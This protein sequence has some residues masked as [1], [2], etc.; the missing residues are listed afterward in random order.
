MEVAILARVVPSIVL[1][2]A[3]HYRGMEEGPDFQ[4]ALNVGNPDWEEFSRDKD[5]EPTSEEKQRDDW[6]MLMRTLGILDCDEFEKQLVEFLESGLFEPARIKAVI[7]RYVE[8]EE[9]ML[10]RDAAQRFLKQFYWDHRVD[11]TQLVAEAADL[12]RSAGLLDPYV[13]TRL[14]SV[15]AQLSGG[16]EVG[17]AFID[18]WILAFRNSRQ[19]IEI[20]DDPFNNPFNNPLHPKIQAEF[21]AIKLTA[22]ANATI[23]EACIHIIENGGWGTLQEVALKQAT[24]ADFEAAIRETEDLDKFLRFMRQMIKMRREKNTYNA[25]FGTATERFVGACRA[26]VS[27]SES[28]RLAG[29]VK[30]MFGEEL[31]FELDPQFDSVGKTPKP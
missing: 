21:D 20:D 22:Q 26:I 12:T 17:D 7:D 30:R 11:E 14:Q 4:F 28:S 18:G 24:V 3:I 19:S 9:A 2:A 15:L 31:A 6:R 25:F 8:E 5:E 16:A 10:A 27:D 23:V 1:F 13:A 29:V